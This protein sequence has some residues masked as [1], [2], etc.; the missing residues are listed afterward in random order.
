MLAR[1]FVVVLLALAVG[2]GA[3]RD[4]GGE[5][6]SAVRQYLDEKRVVG[7]SIAI[8]EQ[9]KIVFAEGFGYAN[10]ET[11]TPA[12][13]E[14]VYRLASISK[15][16]TAVAVLRLAEM[17][18]LDL[19]ADIRKYLPEF[20][21]KGVTITVRHLLSH[22]SGI[23][24]YRG[25]E[26]LR[27]EHFAGPIPALA[28]FKDDPLEHLPGEKY[29]YSTYGYTV[30]AAIIEKVTGKSY[31]DAMRQLVWRPAGMTATDV[32][33]QRRVVLNR[34]AGYEASPN[35]EYLNSRQVDL[36]YK[37]GGGGLVSTVTDLCRFGDAVLKNRLISETWRHLMWSRAR[38]SDASEIPYGL[39]WG[40]TRYRGELLISHNGAQ[41]GSRTSF[42]ILPERGVVIAVLTNYENHSVNELINLVADTWLH[43]KTR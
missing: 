42:W 4:P 13:P 29:T 8:A 39:G 18:L 35:G 28:I 24:H 27:N 3:S 41:Q 22:T 11:R 19:D 33:D 14:T 38:L 40:V 1:R 6:R 12:T 30:I 10:L 2:A 26:S 15:P 34:A 37:W 23:R 20:P 9:G 17:G 36:S 43:S 5:L 7:C 32:E 31:P 25:N 21:D 16:I